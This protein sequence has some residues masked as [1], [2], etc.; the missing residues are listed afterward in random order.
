M[1]DEIPY[2]I[3]GRGEGC[4]VHAT[5]KYAE[6]CIVDRLLRRVDVWLSGQGSHDYCYITDVLTAGIIGFGVPGLTST[7]VQLLPPV[8]LMGLVT[9]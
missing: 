9:V 1:W 3:F 6:W 4:C 7:L 8:H 2:S 5:D